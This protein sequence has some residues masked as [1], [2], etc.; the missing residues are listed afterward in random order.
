M[1]TQCNTSCCP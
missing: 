1:M